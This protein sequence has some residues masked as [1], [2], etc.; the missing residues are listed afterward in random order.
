MSTSAAE[1][2]G[3]SGYDRGMNDPTQTINA[4]DAPRGESGQ[5][6]LAAGTSV[7]LRMWSDEP[8]AA[9]KAVTSR[10]YETVGYVLAGR[11]EL[12]LGDT[13]VPLASGDS[14]IVPPET[15]HTYRILETFSALEATSPPAR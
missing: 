3:D 1:M 9:A 12:H 11:A 5:L 4:S 2:R 7:A 10:P 6:R 15:S 13:V 8:P 14:W